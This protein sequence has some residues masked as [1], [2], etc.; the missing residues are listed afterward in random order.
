MGAFAV[1]IVPGKLDT[2]KGWVADLTGPRKAEFDDM[3]ARYDLTAHRAYLQPTPDGQHMVVVVMDGP[4]ADGFMP[5]LAA[6]D[7]EFDGWFRA[8][9]ADVHGIDFSGPLPPA[10][11]R[12]L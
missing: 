1:P 12:V 3:N 2:W 9:I 5:K 11:E 10:P 7:N 8:G 4:G 6:S